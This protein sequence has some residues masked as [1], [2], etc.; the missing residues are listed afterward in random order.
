MIIPENRL[1]LYGG[2]RASAP[3]PSASVHYPGYKLSLTHPCAN[4]KMI[5]YLNNH[6]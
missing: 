1:V 5:L 2:T 4:I 6:L 3:V